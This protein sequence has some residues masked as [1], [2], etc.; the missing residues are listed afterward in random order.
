MIERL[1]VYIKRGEDP[2][3]QLLKDL[4]ESRTVGA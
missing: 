2:F 4:R 1:Q 3:K